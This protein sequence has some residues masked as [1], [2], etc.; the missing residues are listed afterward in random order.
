MQFRLYLHLSVRGARGN[1][2]CRI[3]GGHSSFCSTGAAAINRC[4]TPHLRALALH[5]FIAPT[6]RAFPSTVDSVP[7]RY[8]FKSVS[9][10]AWLGIVCEADS[11]TEF[12]RIHRVLCHNPKTVMDILVAVEAESYPVFDIPPQFRHFRKFIDVV[13]LQ[14]TAYLTA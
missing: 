1:N 2:Y 14:P 10:Q 3:P 7:S 9:A 6:A 11:R 4:F 5:Q 12:H 13:S 8:T